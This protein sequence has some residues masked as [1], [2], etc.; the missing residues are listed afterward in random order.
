MKARYL[1]AAAV[2]AAVAVAASTAAAHTSGGAKTS[3]TTLTVWLQ[4]E[5]QGGWGDVLQYATKKFQAKNPDVKVEVQTLLWPEHLTK[6]NAALAAGNAPDVVEMGNTET[7]PYMANGAF[8]ALQAK[9]FPNSKTWLS[10]LKSSCSFNGKLYC[11][12]Y[13]AGARAVIYRKDYYRQAGIKGT[14]TTLDQFVAD[15][16]KLMKKFGSDSNFSAYYFAGKNWYAA[17][18][19]VYDWGGRIAAFKDSKWKGTLD[20]PQA[21]A[22]LTKLKSVVLALSRAPKT[23]DEAHPFPSIPFAQ[24]R[25]AS[26]L[27]NGWE[28]PY[29][30][31]AKVGDPK[32]APVMA[33]YPMPSHVKGKYMPT[34]L[35]GSDLAI[36]ASSKNKSLATQWIAAF[37]DTKAERA[38]ASRSNIPNTTTL[39]GVTKDNP[40]VAPFAEAAKYSWFVPTAANW[41]NVENANVLQN[42]VSSIMTGQASVKSATKSASAQITKILNAS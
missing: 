34:F 15:G 37:T 39:A 1:A 4:P 18:G 31:D 33:A 30:L 36:P 28:W 16:K 25:V 17:M 11:V 19:F 2:A 5:A 3:A 41:V 40:Q 20:S 10:G 35:G 24:G 8:A 42:M 29:T 26:F 9:D 23:V 14:P 7:T 12:P 22:A 6:L 38:I 27:G 32:L 13:Y 21:Q